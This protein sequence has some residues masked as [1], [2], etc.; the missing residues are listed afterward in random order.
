MPAFRESFADLRGAMA[1][2]VGGIMLGRYPN[3]GEETSG[4]GPRT[5]ESSA[6]LQAG[7]RPAPVAILSPAKRA[8]L[9]AF[10]EGDG[11]LHKSRG[12]W[13]TQ[14]ATPSGAR[15]YGMTIADLA[16]E[17]MLTV[18]VTRKS[19]SARLT[20]RGRWFAQTLAAEMGGDERRE[21]HRLD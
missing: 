21:H 2:Q 10:L 5:P 8:A 4:S 13:T 20:S 3:Q 14:P 9:L 19:A 11:T 1:M 6:E 16:R 17:G 12:V 7:E 18:N 15:I